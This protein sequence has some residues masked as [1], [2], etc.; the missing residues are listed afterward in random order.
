MYDL[1]GNGTLA[2]EECASLLRAIFAKEDLDDARKRIIVEMDADGD[3][4]DSQVFR[5]I[6]LRS[7]QMIEPMISMRTICSRL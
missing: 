5:G 6:T 1:D 7:I 2:P 4:G 3:G